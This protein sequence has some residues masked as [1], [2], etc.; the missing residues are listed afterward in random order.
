MSSKIKR[1]VALSQF[2]KTL[3]RL[4]EFEVK[5]KQSNEKRDLFFIVQHKSSY[6]F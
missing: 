5:K 4:E 3:P 2:L 1:V 6:A